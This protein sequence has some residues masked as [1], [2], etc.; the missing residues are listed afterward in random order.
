LNTLL[1]K[2]DAYEVAA[3]VS[4]EFE[5]VKFTPKVPCDSSLEKWLAASE[6]MMRE[7]LKKEL[8]LTS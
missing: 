4:P 5:I 6:K 8:L 1:G 7:M 3:M 2:I